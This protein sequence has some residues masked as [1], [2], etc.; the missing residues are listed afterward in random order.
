MIRPLLVGWSR[1][2]LAC[3]VLLAVGVLAL[4]PRCGGSN[5]VVP[6]PRPLPPGAHFEGVWYSPTYGELHIVENG[7]R[8]AGVYSKDVRRGDIE[9]QAVGD[10]L[11]YRWTEKR[12]LVEGHPVVLRGRG[13]FQFTVGED[14]RDYLLGEWGDDRAES[15]GGVWRVYRLKDRK[16]DLNAFSRAHDSHEFGESVGSDLSFSEGDLVVDEFVGN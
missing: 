13:F 2:S 16:P 4:L 15:G 1:V 3:Y 9:G 7:E 11:R 6:K 5:S 12:E 8:V 10:L 14:G